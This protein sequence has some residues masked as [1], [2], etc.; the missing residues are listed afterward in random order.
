[1]L[2]IP[3]QSG[4]AQLLRLVDLILWDEASMGH[5]HALGCIDR[6]M[7]ILR[8]N[9]REFGGAAF[10]IMGDFRQIPPVVPRGNRAQILA[11]TMVKS[12]LWNFVKYV[13]LTKNMRVQTALRTGGVTSAAE[14]KAWAE[15]LL[16]I[17]DGKERVIQGDVIQVSINQYMQ[18]ST[19]NRM[20]NPHI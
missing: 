17:G 1:M 3:E 16:R 2:N 20:T 7:R 11:A 9:D 6:T 18:P 19:H 8:K 10:V 5:Q 13:H 12:S 4:R 15:Y 14:Y